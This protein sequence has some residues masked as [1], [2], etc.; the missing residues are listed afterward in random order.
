MH[1]A[2][3]IRKIVQHQ[4]H[5]H[6]RA[7]VRPLSARRSLTEH[8]KLRVYLLVDVAQLRAQALHGQ[9]LEHVAYDVVLYR[10]F[11]VF[12]VVVAAQEG[13]VRGRAHLA[14]LSCQL[15]TRD[16]GHTY[17]RKQQV[18]LQL[19]HELEGIEPVAGTAH[20]AET[21][22]LPGYHGAHR[23]PEFV[24]VVCDYY[25]VKRL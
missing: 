4:R 6:G 3:R 25:G 20:K 13:Y 9:G 17:V 5:E 10:L 15:Y 22:F 19:L 18:R 11:C 23:F 1:V 8:C 14:H 16:K 7:Q 24:L 21:V 2:F 12:K